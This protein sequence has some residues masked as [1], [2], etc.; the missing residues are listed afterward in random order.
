MDG[1]R[2][3]SNRL[4]EGAAGSAVPLVARTDSP[5][6]ASALV[7]ARKA[8]TTP[9]IALAV[10]LLKVRFILLAPFPISVSCRRRPG[11]WLRNDRRGTPVSHREDRRGPV[12][13]VQ[14]GGLAAS[15]EAAV[16]ARL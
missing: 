11:S 14:Q 1:M 12:R 8:I 6:K 15:P 10:V 13:Q 5:A 3:R 2:S 9:R 7:I 4:R 16:F